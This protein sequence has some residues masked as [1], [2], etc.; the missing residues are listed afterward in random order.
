MR[1]YDRGPEPP[2]EP[3]KHQAP[4]EAKDLVTLQGR[5]HRMMGM[6][7]N[8]ARSIPQPPTRDGVAPSQVPEQPQDYD[9]YVAYHSALGGQPP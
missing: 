7:E 8:I 5:L 4:L 3:I 9:D 1:D 6:L 2:V